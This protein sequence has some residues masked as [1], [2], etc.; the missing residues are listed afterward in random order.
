MVVL[1]LCEGCLA[2]SPPTPLP[3]FTGA[4]GEV[5][6]R[7]SVWRAADGSP[8]VCVCVGVGLEWGER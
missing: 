4:R 2:P 6:F 8:R 1:G 7:F 3:R 5:S